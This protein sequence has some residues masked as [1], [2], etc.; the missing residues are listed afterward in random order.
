[1]RT[2]D[3]DVVRDGQSV[4]VP[5]S[6]MDSSQRVAA[7]TFDADDHHPHRVEEEAS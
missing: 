4:K 5:I 1:M 7:G 6:L 3:D 2:Y